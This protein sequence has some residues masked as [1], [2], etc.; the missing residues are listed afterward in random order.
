MLLR[1]P[2]TSALATDAGTLAAGRLLPHRAPSGAGSA[3]FTGS[4]SLTFFLLPVMLVMLPVT[5]LMLPVMLIFYQSKQM[6]LPMMP[7][8]FLLTEHLPLNVVAFGFSQL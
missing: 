5:L 6:P 4:G 1:T 8:F 2:L 7:I 3:V